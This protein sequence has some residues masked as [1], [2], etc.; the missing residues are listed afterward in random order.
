MR[1]GRLRC[2]CA[3]ELKP[4]PHTSGAARGHGVDLGGSTKEIA[5][6]IKEKQD[7]ATALLQATGSRPPSRNPRPRR[8]TLKRPYPQV[9]YQPAPPQY[10]QPDYPGGGETLQR[11]FRV[12][13]SAET[14]S[15]EPGSALAPILSITCPTDRDVLCRTIEVLRVR[16][17]CC[18][19][20]SRPRRKSMCPF[21][22][23][24]DRRLDSTSRSCQVG[25]SP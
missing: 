20:R 15:P 3:S 7:Q 1:C 4:R 17:G 11:F 5:L 21:P 14:S 6:G 9:P 23:P 24:C 12:V 10:Q 16:A 19:F 8:I 18:P 13:A 2:C 25:A 22:L